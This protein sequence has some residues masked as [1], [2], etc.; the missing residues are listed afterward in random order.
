MDLQYLF[1]IVW[2]RK[3]LLALAS[4]AAAALAFF[5]VSLLPPTYKAETIIG[6]GIIN[7]KG[8]DLE[9][10]NP[11]LQQYQVNSQFNNLIKRMESRSNMRQLTY[12]LLLHDLQ[13]IKNGGTPFRQPKDELVLDKTAAD[14]LLSKLKQRQDSLTVYGLLTQQ[15]EETLKELAES[16]KYDFENLDKNTTVRRIEDTDY[17]QVEFDSENPE[18]S[19]FAANTLSR[20]FIRYYKTERVQEENY[21]IQFYDTLVTE[22]KNE[23]DAVIRQESDYKLNNGIVN[24]DEQSLAIISQIKELEVALETER[25]AIDGY[26]QAIARL[27]E[28]IKWED[29]LKF[30]E[31][32]QSAL[33]REEF[34][35][36]RQEKMAMLDNFTEKGTPTEYSQDADIRDKI[37]Q[38]NNQIR[39]RI[40]DLAD[41]FIRNNADNDVAEQ[42]LLLRINNEVNLLLAKESVQSYQK[43]VDEL[44]NRA[45]SFVTDEAFLTNI[46]TQKDILT[47]EYLDLVNK[48][49]EARRLA[50]LST[51][52]L[53]IVEAAEVPDEPESS[54]AIFIAAF[55]AF[56]MCMMVVVLLVFLGL[57]D[58]RPHSAA[59]FQRLT[60]LPLLGVLAP[61]KKIKELPEVFTHPPD[62]PKQK[63]FLESL[64]RI[65]HAIETSGATSFL[66]T[67]TQPQQGKSF[68]IL[69]LAHSLSQMKRRVLIIDT[70]L[71][72]NSLSDIANKTLE[73]N[74][75]YNGTSAE[76]VTT[77][78]KKKASTIQK[79]LHPNIDIVGNQGSGYSPAELLNGTN[80]SNLLATFAEQYDYIFLES[81]PMNL[82]SDT[83]ELL[84][85]VEKVIVVVD[86]SVPFTSEDQASMAFLR[87]Q[88]D[89]FMGAV[90]N[91]AEQDT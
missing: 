35:T 44:K 42:I 65:R 31:Y 63:A 9:R 82:Y 19:A 76:L 41:D 81:P 83:Q 30:R 74:P 66:F 3:W 75:L 55:A 84:D 89:K 50:L 54:K 58:N 53:Q 14:E 88:G 87:E 18:L 48:Y 32:A 16:F 69:S 7:K 51:S 29:T 2:N 17:I 59:R 46:Q 39:S 25:K 38:K 61:M 8:I 4:V 12:H 72:N 43:A 15:E 23:I 73:N 21:T 77:I 52:P 28:D 37:Q 6:T 78:T 80:F 90:L 33:L 64:R 40:S 36:M 5:L 13:A 1:Q 91:K 79:R 86:A 20:E 11:F 10:E 45:S 60:G 62:N 26:K 34:N 71:R 57:L 47:Q 56:A 68:L 85:Y 49:N 27:N 67:S 22:K 24:L 70:N